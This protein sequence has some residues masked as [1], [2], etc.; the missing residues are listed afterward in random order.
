MDIMQI[1]LLEQNIR[2]LKDE[3]PA[4]R[5]LAV[6]SFMG[7]K[8]D[9]KTA[10]LLCS[11]IEDPD[12]GVRNSLDITLSI[13]GSS[14]IPKFLVK[15]IS[16]PDIATRN[17]A[18]DILVKI[19]PPAVHALLNSLETDSDDDIKFAIDVLGLIGET[20]SA[21]KIIH[22]M[23][24]NK[25]ENVILA[26][27]E[28][29]GN[30]HCRK[31]AGEL[32][33][34]YPLSELYQPTIIEALGKTGSTEAVNFMLNEYDKS[35][36]LV[37]FAII[38]SLGLVGDE[39]AFNFLIEKLNETYGPLV[40]TLIESISLLKEKYG[41]IVAVD[42][43]FKEA[44]IETFTEGEEKYKVAAA[45]LISDFSE[46]DV[47]TA[48]L[49]SLGANAEVDSII[50]PKLMEHK[51]A[52]VSNLIELLDYK[53]PNLSSLIEVVKNIFEA[54][55]TEDEFITE[56]VQLEK[57]KQSLVECLD[58]PDEEVRKNSAELLF[59]ID[60]NTALMF[61]DK[62]IED[63][64]MWNRLKLLD[65]LDISENPEAKKAIAALTED[66][67]EMVRERASFFNSGNIN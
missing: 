4:N 50:I 38:E 53:Q 19:G 61:V 43:R 31:C 51:D 1:E 11:L 48:C 25:N 64:N 44:L 66:P 29:I 37:K 57:L 12:K 18:G 65:L 47:L 9:E 52:V 60:E 26:C 16:A 54:G 15:Y 56:E 10:E 49:N 3:D 7:T 20:N 62:M 21:E 63:D 42:D 45:G 17:L 32:I 28:A 34:I 23:K 46:K 58:H 36:D 35:D 33:N 30:I 59:S 39:Q 55:N 67:D 5:I 40:G 27:I 24:T 22:I 41:L 6:E 8:L 2:L 14:F 13:N